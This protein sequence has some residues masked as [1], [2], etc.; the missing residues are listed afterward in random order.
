MLHVAPQLVAASGPGHK[1]EQRVATRRVA[2]D[3]PRKLYRGEPGEV[4]ECRLWRVG[5]RMWA[6]LGLVA[7]T[8]QR[9]IDAADRLGWPRTTAT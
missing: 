9:V 3:R 1:L 2:I 7:P 5:K 6:S 8:T 4:G